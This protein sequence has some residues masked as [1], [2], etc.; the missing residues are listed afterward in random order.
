MAATSVLSKDSMK[1]SLAKSAFELFSESGFKEVKLEQVAAR[2]GVT[3]GS[4][5]WHY[6]SKKSLILASCDCYYK[7]WFEA[8]RKTVSTKNDPLEQ[9][10]AVIQ[11]TTEQC[12]LDEKN[13][14]FTTELFSLVIQDAEVKAG[15]QCF[16]RN[17]HRFYCDILDRINASGKFFIEN[18]AENIDWLLSAV[19]GIKQRAVIDPDLC[20]AQARDHIVRKLVT[21]ALGG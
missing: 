18:P 10:E 17:V 2:A 1:E 7:L 14:I 4:F 12:L 13:R 19:E 5:Y 8:A 11:L 9:L 20:R 21:I 6:D 3:K 16:Y 15:W